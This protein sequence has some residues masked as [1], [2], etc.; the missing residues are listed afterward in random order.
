MPL[1]RSHLHHLPL[2][3]HAVSVA[4][5]KTALAMNSVANAI[6]GANAFVVKPVPAIVA[7]DRVS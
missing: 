6:S 7:Q 3:V 4:H 5:A 1:P 2:L